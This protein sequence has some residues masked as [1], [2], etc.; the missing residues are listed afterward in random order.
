MF[1]KAFG[2]TVDLFGQHNL[3]GRGNLKKHIFSKPPSLAATK[4]RDAAS[5]RPRKFM[6][7]IPAHPGKFL[8]IRF[9][10]NFKHHTNSLA[11]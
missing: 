2:P 8:H 9:K 1:D 4:P 11:G 6:E 5:E 7:F 10:G 3:H